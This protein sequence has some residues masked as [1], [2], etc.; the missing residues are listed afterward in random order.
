MRRLSAQDVST[1][2]VRELGLD[3]ARTDLTS[4]ESIATALR[5]AASLSCPCSASTLVRQVV[6]PLVGLVPDPASARESA[7][8][9]LESILAHGDLLEQRENSSGSLLIY[10]APPSFVWRDSGLALLIGV[11]PDQSTPLPDELRSRVEYARHIRRLRPKGSTDLRSELTEFGLVQISSDRWL[12]PPPMES[13]AAF[14]ERMDTLLRNAP[15]SPE[16]PGLTVLNSQR[17]VRYYRGRWAE[18]R[19]LTGRF[20]GR[21]RQAYGADL[22]CY[23]D[24]RNGH[25]DRFIDL[26]ISKKGLRGC[27]EAWHLQLA[28]D[29]TRGGDPQRFQLRQAVDNSTVVQF[30]S[31]TPSWARRR[32]DAV[33]DPDSS[34]GCLFAYR[35]R[36]AELG[37]EL[38]FMRDRLW[39]QDVDLGSQSR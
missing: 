1:E 38:A 7:E 35:F 22:W 20:I 14:I 17:P 23:V 13:A 6:A 9:V 27:D 21:R 31:P 25:P 28:I 8:E 19:S 29:S 16:V 39:L 11:A 2:A 10:G 24:V 12:K 5:R 4:V 37:E 36:N 34:D 18:P 33:G 30:F 3:P 32:W 15:V 26:P